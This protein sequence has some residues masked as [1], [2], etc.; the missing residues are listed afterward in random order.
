MISFYRKALAAAVLASAVLFSAQGG[1]AVKKEAKKDDPSKEVIIRIDNKPFTRDEL[2]IAVSRLFPLMS[3]H[4]SVTPERMDQIKKNALNILI[5]E[6]V[7]TRDARSHKMALVE[8]KDVDAQIEN[9]KKNLQKGQTIEQVLKNSN[10]TM[11]GLRDHFR[12]TLIMM[13]YKQKKGDELRKK[14]DETVTQAYMKDYYQKNLGKFKEPEQIH[15]RTI[16]IK[17][18]PSGGTKVWN[19]ALKKTNDLAKRA[20]GGEDFAKLA[21]KYSQDP[22]AKKGGDVGWTHVGSLFEEIDAAAETMKPGEISNPVMTIYGYHLIKLDGKKAAVQKK[23]EELNK[24]KLKKDLAAKEYKRL[25]DEWIAELRRSS[26]I[27]YVAKDVKELM[28]EPAP[29]AKK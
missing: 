24:E 8:D 4:G 6:D 20:R 3:F 2:D 28:A 17:A 15:L 10:M 16:L 11:A 19:E 1:A 12:D 13:H 29:A 25:W 22:Y 23:F 7:I 21:E 14:A 26:K 27:E 18:D 5:N 9:L